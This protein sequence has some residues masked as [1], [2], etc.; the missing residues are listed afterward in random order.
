[1]VKFSE[2]IR[3]SIDT[4]ANISTKG[5]KGEHFKTYKNG[6]KWLDSYI[7]SFDVNN[8]DVLLAYTNN[9]CK[10]INNYIRNQI[11]GDLCTTTFVPNEIIVFNN[12]YKETPIKL[13]ASSESGGSSILSIEPI[14]SNPY[15]D[16]NGNVFYTSQKGVIME[17]KQIKLQMP[18]FPF[19][20]LF[21]LSKKLDINF[22][23]KNL[24][25]KGEL[26]CPI[27]F[28]K[29]RDVD[30][31]QLNCSHVFCRKCIKLWLEQN[32][33]CPYCRIKVE[34]NKIIFDDDEVLSKMI[35]EFKELTDSQILN[36]WQ[37]KVA[38]GKQQGIIYVPIS[39]FQEAFEAIRT[40][41][42]NLIQSIKKHLDSK[43][44]VKERKFFVIRRLWEFYYYS[45]VDLFADISY[46]YCITV[47][48]S[49]GSTFDDV[50]VDCNNIM[51]YKNN[52]TLNCLYTAV[53][54]SSKTLYMLV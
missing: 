44:T 53:T 18:K 52:D 29:I 13:V 28:E 24:K 36:I 35:N 31:A 49:Q 10:E 32:D 20:S 5:C 2:S 9:R 47:H 21:N 19:E 17:C 4:N 27:C 30:V 8:N 39:E 3:N 33:L 54:R 23:N 12:F 51:K 7:S 22:T 34:N 25:S 15:S 37:I 50:Y 48:K 1:M 11:Y 46:G 26:D 40:K 42:K 6:A 43:K 16:A 38:S 41:L 14:I 45:Y